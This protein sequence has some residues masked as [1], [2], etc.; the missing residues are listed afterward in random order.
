KLLQQF[1]CLVDHIFVLGRGAQGSKGVGGTWGLGEDGGDREE[2]K[3]NSSLR[4]AASTPNSELLTV[5]YSTENRCKFLF[6]F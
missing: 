5:F 1:S 3:T 6:N 2:A 4:S